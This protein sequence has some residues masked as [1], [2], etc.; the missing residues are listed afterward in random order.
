EVL[1]PD[2]G[3]FRISQDSHDEK[4]LMVS[5]AFPTDPSIL[6]REDSNIVIEYGDG[7]E[8]LKY[9]LPPRYEIIQTSLP[10]RITESPVDGSITAVPVH[11]P[12]KKQAFRLVA[13]P[14]PGSF[15]VDRDRLSKD[16]K[17]IQVGDQS[18]VTIPADRYVTKLADGRATF[19]N[20]GAG[21]V[22]DF[23]KSDKG[24]LAGA[25]I[26][27]R[28]RILPEA[29]TVTGQPLMP[30]EVLS[31]KQRE[32]DKNLL[33]AWRAWRDDPKD[34]QKIVVYARNLAW[35]GRHQDAIAVYTEGLKIY[36]ESFRLLRHRGHRLITLRQFDLAAEDLAKAAPLAEA[37]RAAGEKDR[38]D[39]DTVEQYVWSS[40]YHLGLAEYFRGN[41]AGAEKAF[42]ATQQNSATDDKRNAAAYWLYNTLNR[43]GRGEEAATL[44]EPVH[45]G[46]E[47]K[48]NISYYE[49]LLMFKGLRTVEQTIDVTKP[50][51]PRY[52]TL[53]Y[54]VANW[55]W[56][57]GEK[58]KAKDIYQRVIDASAWNQFGQLGSEV[59]LKELGS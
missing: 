32:R 37:A 40:W 33:A 20:S 25:Y 1:D 16:A 43:A 52:S 35:M 42:R 58:E 10:C 4:G 39:D 51:A 5:E 34:E 9:I 15:H 8:D 19:S 12:G 38:A 53:S 6:H 14:L 45:E 22:L 11:P 30:D 26:E 36:P 59:A 41:Y 57:K 44:L 50:D 2:S 23:S 28:S 46:M 13:A 18:T 48:D 54:G 29:F 24:S 3:L 7:V 47:V 55:Y 56:F 31:E 27:M 49:L 21:T 17:R